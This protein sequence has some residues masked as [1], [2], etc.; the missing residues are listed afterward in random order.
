MAQEAEGANRRAALVTGASSGIGLALARMLGQEGHGVTMVARRPEKLA[1]AADELRGEGLDVHAVAASLGEEAEE[2][3]RVV[4]AHRERYGRLDV[5]VNNAGVGYGAPIED[6]PTKHLDRQLAVNLRAPI[7][8]YREGLAMLRAAGGEH[9]NALVVNT[10]SIAGKRGQAWLSVY[11]ATKAGLIA[12]TQAMNRELGAAGIKSCAL[13]PGFV[14]TAMTD[15]VKDSVAPQ[16][17]IQPTDVAALVRALLALSPAAVVPEIEF[18]RL[19]AKHE[20]RRPHRLLGSRAER[21]RPAR[22]RPGGRAARLRLGLGGRGLRLGRG[23]R[24]RLA[25]RPGPATIKL[26]S[27]IFQMPARSPAMTAMTAATIDQLSGGRM[28][29]GIGSSGP[30]VAEGWHGQRFAQQLQRTREYVAVV[31]MA[32]ARERVEFHGRDARAAAARRA[33]QGAEADDRARPG[34]DPDLPGGD[35]PEEHGAGRGDRRRLDPDA[36]LAR[37]RRPSRAPL[38]EEGAARVGRSLDGFDIA[39]TVNV[40]VTDDLD[41]ARATRCGRSSP[42]TS[43]GW[44]R[45]SRT[46]TTS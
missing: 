4:A 21:R 32:L 42:S 16:D 2:V 18:L 23:Q 24:A 25:G 26:G 33:G 15:F 13:C 35:R 41:A 29:L 9:G 27:A 44:A 22:D 43:A 6:Y 45:A 14:D 31:R 30:Q 39:P 34:A 20:A 37:A 11:S 40:L 36:L 28:R 5:L 8:F 19:G 7:L 12:F 17:M 3:S 46:S 1:A 10:A 38:L